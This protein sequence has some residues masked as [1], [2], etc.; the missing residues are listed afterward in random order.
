MFELIPNA[1]SIMLKVDWLASS[2][3]FFFHAY[4]FMKIR[5]VYLHFSH[6]YINIFLHICSGYFIIG[7]MISARRY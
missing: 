2:R 3:F 4:I 7:T 1:K 5:N 6:I